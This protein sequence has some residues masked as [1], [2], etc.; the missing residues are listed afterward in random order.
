MGE[1]DDGA[2]KDNGHGQWSGHAGVAV[3]IQRARLFYSEMT[4]L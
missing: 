3:G 4:P 2:G 1:K